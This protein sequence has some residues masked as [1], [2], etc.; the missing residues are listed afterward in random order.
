M[1][2]V[3]ILPGRIRFKSNKL[4]H[5]NSLSKYL[6]LYADGLSGIK[7]TK[8]NSNTGSIL[9]VYNDFDLQLNILKKNLEKAI[10]STNENINAKLENYNKYFKDIEKCHKSKKSILILGAVYIIFKLK[11]SLLGKFSL[12]KN[13]ALLQV[14]SILTLIG[15][16]SFLKAFYTKFMKKIPCDSDILLHSAGTSLSIARESGD[17]ILVF[18][19]KS[20]ADYTKASSDVKCMREINKTMGDTVGMVWVGT[21][22][23]D[24][25]L[26]PRESINIGDTIIVHTGETVPFTGE[27][28]EGTGIVNNLYYN[29]EIS[30]YTVKC[31]EIIQEGITLINGTIKIKV[32]YKSCDTPKQDLP[33][34]KLK[35]YKNIKRYEQKIAI[36]SIIAALFTYII[37]GSALSSLSTVIL[38]CPTAASIA[39]SSGIK[40]YV[41]LLNKHKIYFRNP[42]SLEKVV[43]INNFIFDK[44]G[45]L[46]HSKMELVSVA[47]FDK[48]YSEY[49]LLKICASCETNSFHP[50]S[51]T[52]KDKVYDYNLS[53]L[54]SSI[55]IPAKGISAVYDNKNILIGNKNLMEENNIDLTYALQKYV[56][57][58]N[59][60][61]T[62]ILVSINNK[63]VAII[64]LDNIIKNSS[65]KLINSLKSRGL[66][67][68]SLLTGDTYNKAMY[69]CEKLGIDKIYG[70]CTPEDK[71]SIVKQNKLNDTVLMVGDGVNDI[72]AMKAADIS[73]SFIHSSCDK[74]KIHSDCLIL[75]DDMESIVNFIS[76]SKKSYKIIKQNIFYSKVYNYSLATLS[77]MGFINPFLAKFINTLNSLVVLILNERIKHVSPKPENKSTNYKCYVDNIHRKSNFQFSY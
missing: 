58:E 21:S 73:I 22:S 16:Y 25:I 14:A 9:I 71:V 34:E 17:S 76:L 4:Y 45:T 35:I 37:T 5:N 23:L 74:T 27:I 18:L 56:Y 29:G 52:L 20:L 72:P 3:S 77:I 2:C 55:L 53:K 13:V 42:N 12:C 44:T 38:L 10:S 75:N 39:L 31:K 62:P 50:I 15:G 51:I 41:A 54:K 65:Y 49:E 8:I 64:V 32:T 69:T 48:R 19:F 61:L 67:N 47:I 43:N 70:E 30:S 7:Y 68:I 36:I 40:N 66:N 6:K 28:I 24:E 60:I 1:E 33:F 63:I 46:T 57:Y 26:V 11:Q 59:K